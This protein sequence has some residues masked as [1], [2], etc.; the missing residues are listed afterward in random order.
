M[1][2]TGSCYRTAVEQWKEYVS[3]DKAMIAYYDECLAVEDNPSEIKWYERTKAD[4]IS[5]LN[6]H[7]SHLKYLLENEEGLS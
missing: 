5:K 7:E 3:H 2:T 4:Y 1:I 6:A